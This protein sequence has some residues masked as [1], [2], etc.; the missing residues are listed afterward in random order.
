MARVEGRF[1]HLPADGANIL[2]QGDVEAMDRNLLVG[3]GQFAQRIGLGRMPAGGK[4]PPAGL[5][6]LAHEFEAEAPIASGDKDTGHGGPAF[7]V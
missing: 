5:G 7:R 6:K 1:R 4:H 2:G 3:C